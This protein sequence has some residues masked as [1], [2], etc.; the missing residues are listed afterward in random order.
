MKRLALAALLA[1]TPAFAVAAP[2]TSAQLDALMIAMDTRA[3]LDA[4]LAE[5]EAM[6]QR[7]AASMLPPDADAAMRAQM[8]RASATSLDM[9]REV[10]DWSRLEPVYRQVHAEVFTADE[11]EAMTRFYASPEGRAVLRKMPKVMARVGEAMQPAMHEAMK[12]V[13]TALR[14]AA[15]PPAPVEHH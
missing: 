6:S 4:V 2:P 3:G 1:V 14:R 10:L 5:M 11:V 8:D 9:V 13:E 15:P 12:R 7:M